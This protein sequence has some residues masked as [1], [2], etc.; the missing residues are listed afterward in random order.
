M[1]IDGLKSFF[2]NTTQIFSELNLREGQVIVG[3]I[4]SLSANEALLEIAGRQ[5][6]AKV[7]GNPPSIPDSTAAFRVGKDEQGRTLLRFV[8]DVSDNNDTTNNYVKGINSNGPMDA[9]V[10]K[11]IR[12]SLQ[13]AGVAPSPENIEKIFR[14]VQDFQLKYQQPVNPQIFSFIVA[15]KWPVTPGTILASLVLQDKD[16]RGVLWN[17]LQKSLPEKELAE[18]I[19]KYVLV[20]QADSRA[21][22]GK[23]AAFDNLKS[24][25]DLLAK[26]IKLSSGSNET[27]NIAGLTTKQQKSS[28]E[29]NSQ[30]AHGD[31]L[32][33]SGRHYSDAVHSESKVQTNL[34]KDPLIFPKQNPPPDAAVESK[35]LEMS[36]KL[37]KLEQQKIAGVLEQHI[38]LS[39]SL[40]ESDIVN[41]SNY[42]IPFLLHDSKNGIQELLVKWREEQ[43]ESQNGNVSQIMH[44]SIPT[45][46]MGEIQL[47]MR[48]TAVGVRVNLKVAT[49]AV[50]L[51]FQKNINELKEAI[52]KTN[53]VIAIGLQDNTDLNSKDSGFDLWM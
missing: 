32:P 22:A 25:Q 2:G 11:A 3:K 44:M 4:L 34:G 1:K 5:L 53:A 7:E 46:H 41:N 30:K 45:E 26:L 42:T 17:M 37:G 48:I 20:P 9:V 18:F 36:G 39:K 40:P 8:A 38:S 21:L 19:A 13:K 33:Q 14:A 31:Y 52:G 15:Q 29:G 24:L 47:T 49:E 6:Q 10:L 23:M 50:R 43:D 35:T 16:A 27:D 28:L 12:A 51:I